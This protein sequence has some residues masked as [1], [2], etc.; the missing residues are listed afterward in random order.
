[1]ELSIASKSLRLGNHDTQA[2]LV[3]NVAKDFSDAPGARY[4]SDGPKSGEEFLQD[5]LE[6]KF[7]SARDAKA[8]LFIDLDGTW[9]YASSFI[10]GAFGGLAKKYGAA[11]V[12]KHLSYKSDEDPLLLDRISREI[13]EQGKAV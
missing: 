13:D 6:D 10:S 4:R 1:M 9:G 7:L 5:M 3:I 12:R 11:V 8:V 2:D